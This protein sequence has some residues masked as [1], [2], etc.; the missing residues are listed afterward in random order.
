MLVSHISLAAGWIIYCILHS[1]LASQWL[2]K[3][4][5]TVLK[6]QF[7][8]Y[9]LYY[10][11]FALIG[12]VPLM[13]FQFT[14]PSPKLFTPT[15]FTK[16]SGSALTLFGFFIMCICIRKY[17]L[18]LSGLKS[19]IQEEKKDKLMITGIH[20]YVRHPLYVGTFVFIWG[21]LLLFPTVSLF[22][23]NVII[24]VYTLIGISFE[25]KKL[26][27]QF[28]EAYRTYKSKTPMLIPAGKP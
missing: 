10:T 2:K 20:R 3:L 13:W 15:L 22:I 7:V 28:G 17:F 24:T 1:V 23:T 26:E 18:Q 19:L 8:Y 16:I 25:E 6:S 21:L 14:M 5:V 9:R 27:Q 12:F 11:L 4:T